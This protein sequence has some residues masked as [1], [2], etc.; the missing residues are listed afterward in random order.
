[1]GGKNKT[2]VRVCEKNG[3]YYAVTSD[4]RENGGQLFGVDNFGSLTT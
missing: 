2:S 3:G 4:W 1:L